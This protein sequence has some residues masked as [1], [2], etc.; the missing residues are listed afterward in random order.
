MNQVIN[1]LSTYI[2]RLKEKDNTITLNYVKGWYNHFNGPKTQL[3]GTNSYIAPDPYF[4]YQ[5]DLFLPD[6]PTPNIGIACID[7]F[8]KYAVVVPIDNKQ[9]EEITDVVFKA[10]NNWVRNQE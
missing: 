8:T 6:Q 10:I 1:L 3:K 9:P 7:I 2:R 4:E 5:I